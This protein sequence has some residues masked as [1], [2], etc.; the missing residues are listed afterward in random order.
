LSS[1]NTSQIHGVTYTQA[2][3]CLTCKNAV[4]AEFEPADGLTTIC[5]FD[6]YVKN[7]KVFHQHPADAK[8]RARVLER[9]AIEKRLLDDLDP[10]DWV[11]IPNETLEEKY[12]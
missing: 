8:T 7:K 1:K 6:P 5:D 11:Y 9:V 3:D 2:I 12:I 10:G 4:I